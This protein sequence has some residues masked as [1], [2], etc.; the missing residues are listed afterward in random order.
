MFAGTESEE[1]ALNRIA[2][3]CDIAIVK[4]G[5]NGSMIKSKGMV[6]S[7][8]PFKVNAVDST[9]AGD[10]YAAGVLYGIANSMPLEK[11][12]KIG[13][14]AGSLVVSQIGARINRCLKEDVKKIK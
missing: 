6:Y 2:E 4:T 10:M 8:P 13:N 12:G 11:A 3:Y 9:G 1:E 14:W 7:I 5:K